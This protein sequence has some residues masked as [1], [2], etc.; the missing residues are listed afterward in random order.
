MQSV[1]GTNAMWLLVTFSYTIGLLIFE[2]KN[3]IVDFAGKYQSRKIS[4]LV[5][6]SL[7]SQNIA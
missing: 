2:D 3:N 6:F 1:A 5:I 7:S 4:I